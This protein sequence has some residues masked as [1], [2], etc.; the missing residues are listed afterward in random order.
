MTSH[1]EV[2]NCL[3]AHGGR[4]HPSGV[5]VLLTH[6]FDCRITHN[7]IFDLFYTGISVGWVWRYAG[8]PSQRNLIGWNHIHD[9]G[10]RKLADMGGIT[11]LPW[12]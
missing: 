10:Q 1:I 3:I 7:D 4:F 6:A 5:G 12:R 11:R 8:S 2:D 9:I